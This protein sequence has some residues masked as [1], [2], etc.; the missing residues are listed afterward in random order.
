MEIFSAP[1]HKMIPGFATV[2]YQCTIQYAIDQNTEYI[3][4]G[5][6]LKGHCMYNILGNMFI[7]FATESEM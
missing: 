7:C 4:E 6:K 2:F 3:L 1:T 5:D